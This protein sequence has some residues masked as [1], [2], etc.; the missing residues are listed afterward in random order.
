[1]EAQ[2]L[3]E[4]SYLEINL[5]FKKGGFDFEQAV[6]VLLLFCMFLV[7]NFCTVL[8]LTRLTASPASILF[9]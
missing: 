7:L 3:M 6:L 4:T 9:K 1:M 8:L 5:F 2:I